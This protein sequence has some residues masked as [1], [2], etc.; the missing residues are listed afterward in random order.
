MVCTKTKSPGE[1]YQVGWRAR[2]IHLEL[3]KLKQT[4][5][6]EKSELSD[7]KKHHQKV[8]SK[9]IMVIGN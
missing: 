1:D 9:L 5:K 8:F 7:P 6:P 3:K 4:L 2:H